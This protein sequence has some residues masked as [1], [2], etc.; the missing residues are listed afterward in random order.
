MPGGAKP[1]AWS[2]LGSQRA[3]EQPTPAIGRAVAVRQSTLPRPLSAEVA[4]LNMS[5]HPLPAWSLSRRGISNTAGTLSGVIGV[6][7][8]G[9]MLQ[10]AGGAD[11]TWGWVQ[12]MATSAIQVR[13]ACRSQAVPVVRLPQHC[14]VAKA[15]RSRQLAATLPLAGAG[16]VVHWHAFWLSGKGPG[17]GPGPQMAACSLEMHHAWQPAE[18][19]LR[20][21]PCHACCSAWGAASSSCSLPAAT[22]CL[23]GTPQ[24]S[25]DCIVARETQL[26]AAVT[27]FAVDIQRLGLRVQYWAVRPCSSQVCTQLLPVVCVEQ[28]QCDLT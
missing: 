1:L 9:H 22:A 11:H 15:Q 8:T 28:G 26:D 25:N 19:T 18:P 5:G 4:S 27:D 20:A 2:C 14:A 23:E 6:A 24:S 16:G 3:A 13:G 21:A 17:G 12:A 10:R 7:V